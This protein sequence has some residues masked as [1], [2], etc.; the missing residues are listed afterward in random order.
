MGLKAI[1]WRDDDEETRLRALNEEIY[2]TKFTSSENTANIV[3]LHAT[4]AEPVFENHELHGRVGDG[5]EIRFF[6]LDLYDSNLKTLLLDPKE[7]LTE[8]QLLDI[9]IDIITALVYINS[10]KTRHADGKLGNVCARKEGSRWVGYLIDFDVSKTIEGPDCS[11]VPED[12]YQF[13][14]LILAASLETIAMRE[15]WMTAKRLK[16]QATYRT[17]KDKYHNGVEMLTNTAQMLYA[18][19]FLNRKNVALVKDLFE[20]FIQHYQAKD[21][22][23]MYT[24]GYVRG[25]LL[26]MKGNLQSSSVPTQSVFQK[27]K[28]SE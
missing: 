20:T 28:Q 14:S 11:Y 13:V 1:F 19:E 17:H 5:G 27:R 26:E 21:K 9:L 16:D 18:K 2:L 7:N 24:A 12:V 8:S 10:E 15:G 23:D 25:V 22:L 6:L 4:W 3:R